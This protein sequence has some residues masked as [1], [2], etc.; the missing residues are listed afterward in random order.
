MQD[1]VG[2]YLKEMRFKK[3]K[4]EM[5]RFNVKHYTNAAREQTLTKLQNSLGIF[6][7]GSLTMPWALKSIFFLYESLFMVTIT[8]DAE[9]IFNK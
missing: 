8:H 3:R 7:R 2:H 1:A 6:L 9:I 4:K 5:L